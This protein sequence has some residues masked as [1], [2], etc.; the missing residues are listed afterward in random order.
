MARPG[1]LSFFN[2]SMKNGLWETQ[3]FSGTKCQGIRQVSTTVRH[4][5]EHVSLVPACLA[6]PNGSCQNSLF[7][8]RPNK[9]TTQD[10]NYEIPFIFDKFIIP[11][12]LGFY[13]CP[14]NPEHPQ[15]V[16]LDVNSYPQTLYDCPTN[17]SLDVDKFLPKFQN[18]TISEI[19]HND[20][21][22]SNAKIASNCLKI[23][24][25]KLNR[26]FYKK[27]RSRLKFK[28]KQA[29]LKKQRKK[30]KA[31]QVIVKSILNKGFTFDAEEYMQDCLQ[32]AKSVGYKID[33]FANETKNKVQ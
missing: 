9:N 4:K 2:R 26:H 20:I 12:P 29:K 24:R 23:R 27:V 1:L 30:E 25:K 28:I 6:V 15:N 17:I 32:K 14:A 19:N 21:T 18:L 8:Y 11:K 10:T 3:K 13:E 31:L 22:N 16:I 7:N 5:E 33:L